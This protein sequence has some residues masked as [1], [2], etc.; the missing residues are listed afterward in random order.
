ML[1][2]ISVRN[3]DRNSLTASCVIPYAFE[4]AT[5]LFSAFLK[6]QA[7]I[8]LAC[9]FASWSVVEALLEMG[10]DPFVRTSN[11]HFN[12]MYC[13]SIIGRPLTISNWSA[14]FPQWDWE[15]RALVLGVTTMVSAVFWGPDKIST[16]QALIDAG[17]DPLYRTHSG[18][19]IL[20]NIAASLDSDSAMVRFALSIPG[21]RQLVNEPIR[22]K[23]NKWVIQYK[24][25]R[26]AA[27]FGSKKKLVQ[28]I[29]NWPGS[30]ALTGAASSGNAGVLAVLVREGG[31]DPRL[32]NARG[33]TALDQ[34][35]KL[36]GEQYYNALLS[37]D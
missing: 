30:R 33:R 14:R 32:K 27:W 37:V 16:V 26:L 20:N 9:G 10:A 19:H 17:A 2:C 36:F 25:L 15:A 28:A 21:V 13:A 11:E 18:T 22:A 6:G 4:Q 23:T 5:D 34:A 1:D 7:S 8:L 24:F 12:S 29:S 3:S 35:R 31:A